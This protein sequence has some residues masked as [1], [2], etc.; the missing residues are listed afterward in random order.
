FLEGD[1]LPTIVTAP[2]TSVRGVLRYL[3]ALAKRGLRYSDVVTVLG[4]ERAHSQTG[5]AFARLTCTMAGLLEPAQ[6]A[7]MRELI[8]A[9][10]FGTPPTVAVSA[11]TPMPT[12]SSGDLDIPAHTTLDLT[13][14]AD[15]P[16]AT[17]T[18]DDI[19][20]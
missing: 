16:P 15:P 4:L 14:A 18:D 2:P 3:L 8:A 7:R 1:V 10:G 9:L 6:R 17:R 5:I 12:P 19:A 11:A 13:A 20:F